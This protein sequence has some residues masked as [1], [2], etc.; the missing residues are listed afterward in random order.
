MIITIIILILIIRPSQSTEK[1]MSDPIEL[2]S[3]LHAGG[4]FSP[5]VSGKWLLSMSLQVIDLYVFVVI[6]CKNSSP[7]GVTPQN[8]KVVGRIQRKVE[9]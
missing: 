7:N 4:Y 5:K 3:M 1:H 8:F 9:V 6:T 2:G